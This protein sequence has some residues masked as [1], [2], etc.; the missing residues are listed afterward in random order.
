M[1]LFFFIYFKYEE[2][3]WYLFYDYFILQ[4]KWSEIT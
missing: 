1:I 2:M 3:M 4:L